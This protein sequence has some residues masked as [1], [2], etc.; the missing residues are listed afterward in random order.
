MPRRINVCKGVH[1]ELGFLMTNVLEAAVAYSFEEFWIHGTSVWISA[2]LKKQI[3]FPMKMSDFS[4]FL[5][6]E[7]WVG[8]KQT[9][10][11]KLWMPE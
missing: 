9:Q 8:E 2:I 3:H 7:K 5:H 1:T 11:L 4:A 10:R 6:F